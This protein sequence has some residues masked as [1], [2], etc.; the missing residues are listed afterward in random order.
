MTSHFLYPLGP[1]FTITD[2]T[3]RNTN[4]AVFG[5]VT[6]AIMPKLEVVAGVRYAKDTRQLDVN[7]RNASTLANG[8]PGP[9]VSCGVA[10][11]TA[12]NCLVVLP[13]KSF[14]YVPFTLGVNFK[15]WDK[16]LIYLKWS[17]G[18]R[19][20]G[21]N[22]RG[23]TADTL[24]PF[25]PEKVD[26]YELGAKFEVSDVL[27]VSADV[28]QSEFK[29]IQILTN[30]GFGPGVVVAVSQNA[31]SARIK[32]LELEA[33][34]ALGRLR[35]GASLAL[36]DAKYKTLLPTVVG[37]LPNST[38][39]YTP[40]TSYTL[41]ADYTLPA[42]NM[43]FVLHGDWAWRSRTWFAP[44]PPTDPLSKQEAYGLF[45]ASLTATVD[46]RFT[47][48]VFGK[49]LANKRY[50]SR[51]NSIPTL[52]YMSAYLGDPRTYGVSLSYKF[53]R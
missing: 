47:V 37:I 31:G 22:T 50:W 34:A 44:V 25:G 1:N 10:G 21:Y 23:T 11:L 12:P 13:K 9:V 51:T 49:N 40:T 43:E 48:S 28:F 15:P 35:L 16:T 3:A 19:S 8:T 42:G 27:R 29:D 30:V 46:E 53:S 20:G 7:S 17:R 52:G 2:G 26:S 33:E 39:T 38:F 32:G 4:F 6:F 14:D 24:L 5:Q 41:S 36:L 18:H 45:N